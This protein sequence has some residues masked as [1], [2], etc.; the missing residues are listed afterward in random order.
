M[1]DLDEASKE[2]FSAILDEID[3][4]KRESRILREAIANTRL[5]INGL[6][7]D[8]AALASEVRML[9]LQKLEQEYSRRPRAED[10]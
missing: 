4:V 8:V 7:R 5:Q 10:D 2:L 9:S 6:S 1:H 3:I